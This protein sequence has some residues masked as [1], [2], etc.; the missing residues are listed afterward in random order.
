MS[1]V[2]PT[3]MASRRIVEGVVCCSG[4]FTEPLQDCLL[5]VA[6][7]L[8]LYE[9]G[10]FIA[11]SGGGVG[12]S[13]GT[14]VSGLYFASKAAVVALIEWHAMQSPERQFFTV[15]PGRTA[16]KLTA[17]NGSDPSVPAAFVCRLLTGKYGH[18]SGSLLAAQRDDL[19]TTPPMKLRRVPT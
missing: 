13:P 11:L 9:A 4:S 1:A 17:F 18:L 19:D 14:D 12:G 3:G 15:A 2:V 7:A 8:S 5:P 16:T 10:V 6:Q